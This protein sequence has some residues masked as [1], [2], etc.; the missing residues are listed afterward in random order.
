MHYV[1]TGG[2]RGLGQ[3]LTNNLAK[4]DTVFAPSSKEWDVRYPLAFNKDCL[5]DRLIVNAAIKDDF[6]ALN[7]DPATVLDVLNVNAVGALRTVQSVEHCLVKGSKIVVLTSQMGSSALTGGITLHG[8]YGDHYV[9]PTYSIAYRMSK[10]A[11]NKLVQCLA[12]DL[13]SKGVSVY[14]IDPGWPKTDMGGQFASMDVDY[15]ATS[16]LSTME[17]LTIEDSGNFYDWLGNRLE[18]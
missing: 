16:I 1:I 7:S 2:K 18:W 13:K 9:P 5:I 11:L 3:A 6:T 8:R 10:A 12:V 17:Q 4:T 14:A 15:C